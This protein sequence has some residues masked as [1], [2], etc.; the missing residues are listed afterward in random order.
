MDDPQRP[1]A[2]VKIVQDC[3]IK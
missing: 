2:K 3:E 1:S